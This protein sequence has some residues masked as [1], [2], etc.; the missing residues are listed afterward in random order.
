MNQKMTSIELSAQLAQRAMDRTINLEKDEIFDLSKTKL[1]TFLQD[2][3]VFESKIDQRYQ[4]IADNYTDTA[5]MSTQMNELSQKLL[6][7]EMDLTKKLDEGLKRKSVR[8]NRGSQKSQSR[9]KSS[10]KLINFGGAISSRNSQQS[11]R[12]LIKNDSAETKELEP[13]PEPPKI[14]I[15]EV[16]PLEALPQVIEEPAPTN[17][18]IQTSQPQ[19]ALRKTKTVRQSSRRQSVRKKSIITYNKALTANKL[20]SPLKEIKEDKEMPSPKQQLEPINES[21]LPTIQENVDMFQN[22]D[23]VGSH[24]SS[25]DKKVT[26]AV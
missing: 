9:F 2:W 18:E 3:A 12:S 5:K 15:I 14:E 16:K 4:S 6:S 22:T 10:S 21:E 1:Q 19:P 11:S 26:A 8:G 24:M 13:I 17:I 23:A 20:D 7:L 25:D